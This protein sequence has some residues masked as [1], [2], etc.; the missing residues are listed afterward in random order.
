MPFR[1]LLLTLAVLL[2]TT[3]GG[4]FVCDLEAQFRQ[5]TPPGGPGALADPQEQ[6]E[7][8]MA[9]ARWNL[10]PIR[11][12]P[13]FGL[14]QVQYADNVF[15]LPEGRAG[16]D[17]SDLTA[18]VGAGLT[19]YLPIGPDVIWTA[20]AA[21]AYVWWRDQDDR[22][23]LTG[24][25]STALVAGFNRLRLRL[26]ANRR[27]EQDRFSSEE[28]QLAVLR[29]DRARGEAEVRLAGGLWLFGGGSVSELEDRTET[30]G[31]DPRV[32]R[33]DL[34]DRQ[35]T[36]V[37]GG[38]AYEFPNQLRVAVGVEDTETELDP[39][40]RNLSSQG[41]GPLLELLYP[42]ARLTFGLELARRDLE[43]LDGSGFVPLEETT[44]NLRL[45]LQ[46]GW[47]FTFQIYARRQLALS[48]NQQFNSFLE[49]RLGL[50]VAAPFVGDRLVA[51]VFA[52]V[53][54]NDYQRTPG[55]PPRLDDATAWGAS[56]DV[57]LPR[58]LTFTAGLRHLELDSN[59]PGL[60]REVDGV[61]IS[62]G[63][64]LSDELLWR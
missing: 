18:T 2:T 56:L 54:E 16:E 21:P 35:E 26:E 9:E 24:R 15:A 58:P 10:G 33:F 37:Q 23:Q 5:Y 64:T 43:P 41:S 1:R 53:G 8:E 39:G 19:A 27:E 52:E 31:E 57:E 50:S 30:T 14:R 22:R 47:R 3:V 63:I 40:R 20:Q 12:A 11:L 45:D 60:D 62:L 29:Q 6:L 48:L 55:A 51:R 13:S 32:A 4:S 59:L 28:L 36:L 46:P 25:Y 44:G 38:L 49:E 42:G 61:D 17:E 7:E 34:L